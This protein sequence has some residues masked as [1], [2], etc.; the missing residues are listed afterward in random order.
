LQAV[1]GAVQVLIVARVAPKVDPFALNA[2]Q[3][4]VLF[5][6]ALPTALVVDGIGVLEK[7]QAMPSSTWFAFAYL[8]VFSTVVA[9]TCQLFGQRHASAPTA[10]VIMLLETPIGVIGAVLAFEEHMAISQWLGAAVL[11]AGVGMSLRAEVVRE[12]RATAS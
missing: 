8:A 2:V 5:G 12:R 1:C 4:S 6:L 11:L 3:L 7:V 10:A 9:F